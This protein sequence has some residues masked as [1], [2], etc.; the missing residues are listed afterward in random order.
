ME[1]ALTR[2]KGT[3]VAELLDAMSTATGKTLASPNYTIG[4]VQLDPSDNTKSL[5]ELVANVSSGYR[6]STQMQYVRHPASDVINGLDLSIFKSTS[7]HPITD[8]PSLITEFNRVFGTTLST[9]D[10]VA[11]S[12][13]ASTD[14]IL[15]ASDSSYYFHPGTQVNMG[16]LG[17]FDRQYDMSGNGLTWP[18][19]TLSAQQTFF[20]KDYFRT[21]YNT[22]LGTTYTSAQTTIPDTSGVNTSTV[23]TRERQITL[24]FNDG[25]GTVSHNLYYNRL[26]LTNLAANLL[27]T[28]V[29]DVYAGYLL[30]PA[31][32]AELSGVIAGIPFDANELVNTVVTETGTPAISLTF[33][34]AS[35]SKYFKDQTTVTVTRAPLLSTILSSTVVFSL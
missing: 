16:R 27:T 8:V 2:F 18:A 33:Q 29:Y 22:S 3:Y 21:A 30:D 14:T 6:R 12:I 11:Q 34:A 15:T 32:I 10:F 13:P 25:T 23:S 1:M 9:L 20:N 28:N 31:N 26:S 35:N 4:T 19:L 5:V 24:T 7:A 17:N